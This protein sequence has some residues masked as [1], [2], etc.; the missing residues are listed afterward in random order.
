MLEARQGVS[1][2]TYLYGLLGPLAEELPSGQRLYYGQDALGSVRFLMDGT[3][4]VVNRYEYDPYGVHYYAESASVDPAFRFSGEQW[5]AG[6]GL[7]YLRARYYDPAQGRFLTRDPF[8]GVLNLPQTLNPYAYATNNPVNLTDPSGLDPLDEA[9]RQ[10]FRDTYR[11]EPLWQ[12]RLLRLYSLAYPEEWDSSRFYRYSSVGPHVGL[13]IDGSLDPNLRSEHSRDPLLGPVCL[14]LWKSLQPG[15]TKMKRVY[16][17]VTSGT[18]HGGLQDRFDASAWEAISHPNNPVQVWAYVRCGGLPIWLT[19]V[20]DLDANIHHWAWGVAMGG[21]YG[22]GGSFINTGREMYQ[23]VEAYRRHEGMNFRNAAT[24]V[25]IG[26]AGASY[27]SGLR[28]FV[29][30][31]VDDLF[32]FLMM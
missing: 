31:A 17:P 3:G 28:V 14:G 5:D 6:S 15:T 30:Q 10:T 7:Y 18:L 13:Y 27:G 11:R 16:S 9:W 20:N 32:S 25:L 24:D 29:L 2:T 22:P 23:L 8:A 1:V 12:D 19:G 26:N 21:E 4:D